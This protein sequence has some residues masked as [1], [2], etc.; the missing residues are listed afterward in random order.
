MTTLEKGTSPHCGLLP[1]ASLVHMSRAVCIQKL[2]SK[3]LICLHSPT[4]D[5]FP[6]LGSEHLLLP[7]LCAPVFCA[8]ESWEPCERMGIRIFY[9]QHVVPG[10]EE[11]S[12]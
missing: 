4:S 10:G 6:P 2:S 5:P 8:P 1:V 7:P 3:R 12:G 11:E 9:N